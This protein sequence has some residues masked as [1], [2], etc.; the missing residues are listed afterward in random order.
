MQAAVAQGGGMGGAAGRGC[1][2]RARAWTSALVVGVA[3]ALGG[4]P[5][6]DGEVGRAVAARE[7]GVAPAGAEGG[8]AALDGNGVSDATGAPDP[9]GS[10]APGARYSWPVAPVPVV[11]RSFQPPT[12]R[13]GPGHRGAD[14][15][16]APGSA[17]LAAGAGTVV[18]AGMV[19]G[20]G[21]VSVQHPDGIRTTYEP[22]APLATAGRAVSRGAVLGT[23]RP[24]HPGCPGACLHWG[25]RRD[26]FTYV[27]P[28]LLL[29]PQRVRLLPVPDPWPPARIAAAPAVLRGVR[30]SAVRPEGEPARGPPS[31]A[32][33]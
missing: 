9:T 18:F 32:R 22:V 25:A 15:V 27:D 23:L 17:V 28:L 20:R 10:T 13:Y 2:R 5:A 12:H 8:A 21:V 7:E 30:A 16:A 4:G 14:L 24:G 11:A 31:V 19:A 29:A 26:R 1:A 3:L 6:R 33:P